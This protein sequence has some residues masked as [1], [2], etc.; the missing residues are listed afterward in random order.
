[1]LL[2]LTRHVLAARPPLLHIVG[3]ARRWQGS[4]ARSI[5]PCG[6][7]A[8]AGAGNPSARLMERIGREPGPRR[9]VARAHRIVL[10]GGAP[11]PPDAPRRNRARATPTATTG[12]HPQLVATRTGCLR[13]HPRIPPT[14]PTTPPQPTRRLR[15]TPRD[16]D[17][18]GAARLSEGNPSRP[19]Q[20]RL[21]VEMLRP[22]SRPSSRLYSDQMR[23]Q[24]PQF[25]GSIRSRR[26]RLGS[27]RTL[28]CRKDKVSDGSRQQER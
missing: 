28:I 17:E 27:S 4:S 23:L 22:G 8:R 25:L 2:L 21:A 18:D 12:V 7:Y 6:G 1:M 10:R 14:T 13:R 19:Q 11:P 24:M 3:R 5:A 16:G 20:F 9:A 15:R 26:C